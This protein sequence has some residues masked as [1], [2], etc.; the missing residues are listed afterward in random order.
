M[1][2]RI[3]SGNQTAGEAFT[4][5]PTITGCPAVTGNSKVTGYPAGCLPLSRAG[6][7]PV[8]SE[9]GS[10][11]PEVLNQGRIQIFCQVGH[12]VPRYLAPKLFL[13]PFQ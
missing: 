11:R 8:I 3:S 12:R 6:V 13:P 10:R 4:N 7:D 2:I 5:Y 1:F 9:P